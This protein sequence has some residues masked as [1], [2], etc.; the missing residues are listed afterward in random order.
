MAVLDHWHFGRNRQ[1]AAGERD[2][3]RITLVVLH[4]LVRDAA[5]PW[6]DAAGGLLPDDVR[7]DHHAAVLAGGLTPAT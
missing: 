1:Q 5:D 6:Q 3:E 4:V 2:R 7:V